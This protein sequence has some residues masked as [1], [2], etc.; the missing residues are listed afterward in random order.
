MRQRMPRGAL[1]QHLER[2]ERHRHVGY[3]QRTVVIVL[4]QRRNPCVQPVMPGMGLRDRIGVGTYRGQTGADI[5]PA[6]AGGRRDFRNMR[7]DRH[8][9]VGRRC[10]AS[11][12]RRPTARILGGLRLHLRRRHAVMVQQPDRRERIALGCHRGQ[13]RLHGLQ[14]PAFLGR[15]RQQP[16]HQQH[17]AEQPT[18]THHGH[19]HPLQSLQ[20]SIPSMRRSLQRQAG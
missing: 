2:R 5:A 16:R 12:A 14:R 20:H 7:F 13:P 4:A 18:H 10:A 19:T 9:I 3:E 15:H 1:H 17:Q 8:G 11:R 6:P